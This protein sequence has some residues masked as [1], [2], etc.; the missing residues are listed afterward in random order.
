MK[1]QLTISDENLDL[2]SKAHITEKDLIDKKGVKKNLKI[3]EEK[4]Y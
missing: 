3:T 1:L 4:L 2:N